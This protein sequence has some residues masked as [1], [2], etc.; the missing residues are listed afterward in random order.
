MAGVTVDELPTLTFPATV[1]DAEAS[2]SKS[3]SLT[4]PI[5]PLSGIIMLLVKVKTPALEIVNLVESLVLKTIGLESVVA[6]S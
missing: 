5:V 4:Q 2:V 6:N 3:V 1:N